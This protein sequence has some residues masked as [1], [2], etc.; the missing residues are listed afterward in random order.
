MTLQCVLY[1][2]KGLQVELVMKNST[3]LLF[4]EYTTQGTN[5]ST[6]TAPC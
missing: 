3:V 5:H 2:W 1:V 4:V 6:I